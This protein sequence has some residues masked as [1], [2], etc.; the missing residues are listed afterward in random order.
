MAITET[1]II[2]VKN[3]PEIIN[4]ANNEWGQFGWSVLNIQITHSQDTKTY[5]KGLMD[6]IY[7]DKT[8]ETTT[9][10][11]A[12]ITY[13]RDKTIP[14]YRKIIELEKEYIDI[15][16]KLITCYDIDNSKVK[17]LRLWEYIVAGYILACAIMTLKNSVL[18]AAIFFAIT[19]L[20]FVPKYIKAKKR[21]TAHKELKDDARK[22]IPVFEKRCEEIKD[23][24]AALLG[25]E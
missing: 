10:N 11:Y 20:F 1:K 17:G 24:V 9:I 3:S 2:Q 6:Y 21:T 5:T 4:N 16:D 15:V 18:I 22:D 8:V 13:Q 7:G 19:A 12:T 25:I 23:E 14:N